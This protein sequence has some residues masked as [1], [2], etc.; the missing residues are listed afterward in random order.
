MPYS[1][2]FYKLKSAS[3]LDLCLI[4]QAIANYFKKIKAELYIFLAS[5]W[6]VSPISLTPLPVA[7]LEILYEVIRQPKEGE[8]LT[9]LT[10]YLVFNII[11][12]TKK[13]QIRKVQ[14]K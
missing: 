11:V 10:D 2:P 1:R 13:K 7:E 8:F 6:P 9:G 12:C 14:R 5:Q 4:L 3:G